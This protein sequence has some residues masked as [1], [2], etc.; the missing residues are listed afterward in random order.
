MKFS[1]IIPAKNEKANLA[2][3]LPR[4]QAAKKKWQLEMIVADGASTDGSIELAKK[5]AD[6]VVVKTKKERETIGEG[7]N[8]GAAVATGEL[9][10]FLDAGVVVPDITKF[11]TLISQVFGD[12]KII[13]GTGRVEIEPRLAT[14]A[15]KLVHNVSNLIIRT[16]IALGWGGGKG[17][18]Q[19]VRSAFFRKIGGYNEKLPVAEDN[20]LMR[21]LAK[22]GR[23]HFFNELVVYDDP[24]RYRK[25]GYPKVVSLWILN[26]LWVWL[27][28]RSFSRS[29]DRIGPSAPR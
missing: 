20:D 18:F 17:E 29:W 10:I 28:K 27:F 3:N 2:S 11:L 21:R 24:R 22:L 16:F 5:Y 6:Q 13:A 19:I 23:L 25:L 14:A 9:F 8:R 7:R 4:W 26:Q 12:T 15:D 1:L